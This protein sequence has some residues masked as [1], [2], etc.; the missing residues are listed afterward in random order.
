MFI[1][2]A[3]AQTAYASNSG[4]QGWLEP[5]APYI[6]T[7]A[8]TFCILVGPVLVRRARMK[9]F[10]GE[11]SASL[12]YVYFNWLGISQ[13]QRKVFVNVKRAQWFAIED[14]AHREG[15]DPSNEVEYVGHDFS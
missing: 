6:L 13:S 11:H 10:L 9:R 12:D 8:V 3:F 15:V 1:S 4:T 14:I 7:F 2:S 5:L